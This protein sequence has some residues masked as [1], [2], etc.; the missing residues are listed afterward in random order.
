MNGVATLGVGFPAAIEWHPWAPEC[1]R[2][3][4]FAMFGFGLPE[5]CLVVSRSFVGLI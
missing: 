3:S 2:G 4:L 5:S 1:E